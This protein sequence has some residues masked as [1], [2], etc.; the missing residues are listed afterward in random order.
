MRVP[1]NL[2]GMILDH[3]RASAYA[4][5]LLAIKASKGP[6][7]VLYEDFVRE[8]YRVGRR[9]FQAGVRLQRKAGVLE[10][11]QPDRRRPKERLAPA[12]QNYVGLNEDLLA[13]SSDLV[14]FV[15]AANLTP[16]PSRPAAIAKRIGITAAGTVRK[17]AKAAI[18]SGNVAAA[19]A[20]RGTK[21]LARRGY[22]FDLV[23]NVPAG[24]VPAGNVTAYSNLEDGTVSGRKEQG[25]ATRSHERGAHDDFL[26]GNETKKELGPKWQVLSD[27]KAS[28]FF[29][30]RGVYA[31]GEPKAVMD[32][33]A[34][35]QWLDYYG[36]APDHVAGAAAHRQALEV[37]HELKVAG[38]SAHPWLIMVALAFWICR[39]HAE[40]KPI[41][42]LAI[43]A[44]RLVRYV[45]NGDFGWLLN[46]PPRIASDEFLNASKVATEAATALKSWGIRID[47]AEL[48]CTVRVEQLAQ[49][50]RKHTRNGVV[51]GLNLAIDRFKAAGNLEPGLSGNEHICGWAWFESS[52]AEAQKARAPQRHTAAEAERTYWAQ[53]RQASAAR[54]ADVTRA[55]EA[56]IAQLVAAGIEVEERRLLYASQLQDLG[57]RFG[58]EVSPGEVLP[59]AVARWLNA[60]TRNKVSAWSNIGGAIR[61]EI[62]GLQ[63]RRAA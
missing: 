25:H 59:A 11:W 10:R 22:K 39:T 14:A 44:E 35:R 30:E 17:L 29:Q 4:A 49:M 3:G 31:D 55:A 20:A 52:I 15:L 7:F 50:I 5:H 53:A 56:A 62:A 46:L 36:G 63:M 2:L 8:N 21:L 6:G 38:T 42:S 23:K 9:G 34:W 16:G 58:R 13:G 24:N 19:T 28:R 54:T 40:G 27:W 41:R 47:E 1:C 51:G 26:N 37:V 32:A 12:G 45:G 61:D 18:A 33:T 48:L 60:P 57:C 43:V